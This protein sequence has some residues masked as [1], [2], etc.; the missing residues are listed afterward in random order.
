MKE[1]FNRILSAVILLPILVFCITYKGMD[2]LPLYALGLIT[3]FLGVSEF[4]GF[5]D[6]GLE[7]KPFRLTGYF[8]A[9][10]I[11]TLYYLRFLNQ[12]PFVE[13]SG[14]LKTIAGYF[15]AGYDLVVPAIFLFFVVVFSMQVILRPLEGAIFT[16]ASSVLG[17]LYLAVPLGH[18]ML[19]LSLKNGIFYIWFIAGLT[20]ITDTGAYFGGRW[21]GKHPAGLKVSPKKTW[22]GYVMGVIS[23]GLYVLAL[24]YI[25]LAITGVEAPVGYVE[26]A[27]LAPIFAF[28]SVMGDLS[29]SAMKR[30][31]K[32]KDSSSVIPGHGGSLDVIDA[33]LFTIPIFYFYLKLKEV[34]G[35]PI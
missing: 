10:L 34:L 22:E 20:M 29:E 23:A 33:M 5:S 1:T 14:F 13:V 6:R 24:K 16:V 30:D 19:T 11:F 3:L 8:F 35:N 4:Y 31:A 18:F 9:F 21:L 15:G 7:G 12:Q 28:I 26:S 25:W 2:Y 32:V 27:I 17:V